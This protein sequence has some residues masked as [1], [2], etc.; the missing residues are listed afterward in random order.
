MSQEAVSEPSAVEITL[1]TSR[2][3]GK[4]QI[5][6]EEIADS[7]AVVREDI[8]DIGKLTSE[9]T[10]LTAKALA[11]LVKCMQPLTSYMTVSP[12]LIP[13]RLGVVAEAYI[14]PS[15][16][17]DLT[18]ADGRK[19]LLDL[20]KPAY[21]DLLIAVI[22]NVMPKFEALIR[23]IEAEKLRK[24]T[25]QEPPQGEIIVA[26]PE[27]PASPEPLPVVAVEPPVSIVETEPTPV[28]EPPPEAPQIEVPAP[29]L[30]AERN[31]QIEAISAE[32]LNYLDMLGCEVF[33]Q[34]PVSR[35]FDDW[36]VNLRQVILSFESNEVIGADE[37]FSA[38]YNRVFGKIEDEL[39]SILANEADVEVSLKTLVENRCLL[40]KINEGYAAQTKELVAKDKNAIENLMR[41]LRNLERE[42]SEVEQLKTSYRHPLQKMAKDQKLSELT[43]KINAVKKRLAVAVGTSSVDAGKSGDIDAD[44]KAQSRELEEKRNAAMDFLAQNVQQLQ[45]QLDKLKKSKTS[46]PMKNVAVQQQIFETTEKLLDAKRRLELAEQNSS[47]EIEKLRAEYEEKKQAALGTMQSLEKNIATKTVDNSAGVRKEAATALAEAVK[48]LAQRKTSQQASPSTVAA[49][50]S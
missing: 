40:N 36:M 50:R 4:K 39:A 17:L 47:A 11:S 14:D 19:E 16:H 18:F 13:I 6:I 23:E 41:N 5:S 3:R 34:K 31:A 37:A 46:N 35:Y 9:E 27:P 22:D 29:D 30:S 2:D 25:M 26:A 10:V 24:V 42:K 20:N 1:P 32:T 21:R 28:E 48:S 12:S 38:E 49:S 15:G 7:F 45:E 43:Q 8:Q 44:F 33:E